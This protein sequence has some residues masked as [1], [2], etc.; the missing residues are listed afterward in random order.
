MVVT[1]QL[2]DLVPVISVPRSIPNP[3]RRNA[4]LIESIEYPDQSQLDAIPDLHYIIMPFMSVA[5]AAPIPAD[6]RLLNKASAIGV[7][8]PKPVLWALQM[9]HS[10][11]CDPFLRSIE[12]HAKNTIETIFLNWLSKEL[13]IPHLIAQ[14]IQNMAY[15][16]LEYR[17]AHKLI[18]LFADMVEGLFSLPQVCFIATAYAFSCGLATPNLIQRLQR[19]DADTVKLDVKVHIRVAHTLLS[20]CLSADLS[21]NFLSG[22]YDPKC[23]L[24]DYV[25][26]LRDAAVDFGEKHHMIYLQGKSLLTLAGSPEHQL[27]VYEAFEH[28]MVLLGNE[29]HVRED[30]KQLLRNSE[31]KS[32]MIK[33]SALLTACAQRRD[34]LLELVSLGSL[35]DSAQ[36]L[37]RLSPQAR[38]FHRELVARFSRIVMQILSKLPHVPDRI[39]EIRFFVRQALL[40]L[41]MQRA[42]YFYR[43]LVMKL[44]RLIMKNRGGVPF[45]LAASPEAISQLTEY[46]EKSESVAFAL[47]DV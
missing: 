4:L 8:Q 45:S 1:E 46:I 20:K 29:E 5:F 37:P 7:P 31:T 19:M 27:V 47:L 28:F 38:E 44:D 22:R 30:W 9:V 32:S 17:N 39:T 34:V 3:A 12:N 26:F 14:A 16:V 35:K 25:T 21:G 33:F 36:R 13:T 42:L 2:F 6:T 24:L 10:F 15:A 23:P 18:A 40:S 11:F 41:D 43:T